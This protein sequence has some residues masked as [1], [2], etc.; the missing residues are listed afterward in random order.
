MKKVINILFIFYVCVINGC[1]NETAQ[2]DIFTE[3]SFP[4]TKSGSGE[5]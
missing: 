2:D 1:G 5:F 3:L 4:L